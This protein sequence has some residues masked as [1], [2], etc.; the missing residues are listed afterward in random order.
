M[1]VEESFRVNYQDQGRLVEVGRRE[2]SG[3]SFKLPQN[4]PCSLRIRAYSLKIRVNV[5]RDNCTDFFCDCD[6]SDEK[7]IE[8][9][10]R[11]VKD[12]TTKAP[13]KDHWTEIA[14]KKSRLEQTGDYPFS[15]EEI[16][17]HCEAFYSLFARF[18]AFLA[19]QH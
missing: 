4:D 18:D 3:V 13:D 9:W 14:G 1:T 7:K 10:Q 6:C 5:N 2:R 15:E 8:N 17:Q 16:R 12:M 11:F 19:E